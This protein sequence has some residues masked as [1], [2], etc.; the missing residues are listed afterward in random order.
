MW[1]AAWLA[2]AIL[3]LTLEVAALIRRGDGDTATEQIRPWVQ[4]CRFL[5]WAAWMWLGYHF[6]LQG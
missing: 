3:A 4:R 6:L 1:A 5:A 2:V